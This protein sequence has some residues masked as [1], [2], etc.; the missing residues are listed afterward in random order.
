M[1]SS[2]LTNVHTHDLL[3]SA[4]GSKFIMGYNEKCSFGL[5]NFDTTKD[6]P[7]VEYSIVSIDDE[8]IDR[9]VIRLS[10]LSHTN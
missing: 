8:V 3:Q 4:K 6:D 2:R 7:E 10:Q 9:R 5:L 1:M